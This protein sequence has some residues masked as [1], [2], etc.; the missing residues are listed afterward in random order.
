MRIVDASRLGAVLGRLPGTPR[1]VA[2]GDS[3]CG[4]GCA[5]R[6]P[7]RGGRVA[8]TMGELLSVTAYPRVRAAAGADHGTAALP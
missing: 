8:V 4:A 3:R 7:R 6:A 5:H 2:S 1:V